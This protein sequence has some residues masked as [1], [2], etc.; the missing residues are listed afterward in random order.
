MAV[1]ECHEVDIFRH[2]YHAG[3]PRGHED[4]PVGGAAQI[5]IADRRCV[6]GERG[7]QPRRE[8][9]RQLIVEPERPSAGSLL[10]G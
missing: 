6:N 5:Q 3:L 8:R 2:D 1:Q 4:L 10:R 9:G 7:A